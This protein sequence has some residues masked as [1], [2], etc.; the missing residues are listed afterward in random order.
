M[1]QIGR[2]RPLQLL[3]GAGEPRQSRHIPGSAN[4]ALVADTSPPQPETPDLLGA[5]PCLGEPMASSTAR[6][7]SLSCSSLCRQSSEIRT[8][9]A[10][11]RPSGSVRGAV[12]D[13]CPY[14]D[15]TTGR[16]G[17]IPEAPK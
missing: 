10:N 6:A 2:A 14:R 4:W 13:D 7:P 17:Y 8:G 3:C 15:P 9:C 12:S 5:Y 11:Q 16:V 1:A